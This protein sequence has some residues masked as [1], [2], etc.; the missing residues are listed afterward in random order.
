[1]RI[2]TTTAVT[3]YFAE[4][5]CKGLAKVKPVKCRVIGIATSG[6]VRIRIRREVGGIFRHEFKYVFPGAITPLS[7]IRPTLV[8]HREQIAPNPA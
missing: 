4:W 2:G 8:E 3:P 5:R 1:M 6:Y 7:A